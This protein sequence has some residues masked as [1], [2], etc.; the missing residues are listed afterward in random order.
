[1]VKI[2]DLTQKQLLSQIEK[3]EKIYT[4]LLAER[5]KRVEGGIEKALLMTSAEKKAEQIRKKQAAQKANVSNEQTNEENVTEEAYHLKIDE[6]ELSTMK[7]SGE[8]APEEE[9]V[10]EE[11]RVTQLLQLSKEQLEELR[12]G[13]K[14]E[15]KTKKKG[16]FGKKK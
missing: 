15:E 1:M 2:K 5:Q 4:Q 13:S 11:V 6:S 14:K 12:G 3:Y 9:E 7:S 10:E 8:G 16:M